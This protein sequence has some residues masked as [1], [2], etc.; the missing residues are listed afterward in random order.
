LSLAEISEDYT[1]MSLDSK[2]TLAYK[3]QEQAPAHSLYDLAYPSFIRKDGFKT[4]LS[5]SDYVDVL[6]SIL[7]AG[8][9]V[10]LNF[11]RV[12][13]R[14]GALAALYART[15]GG[16]A[17]QHDAATQNNGREVWTPRSRAGR[18]DDGKENRRPVGGDDRPRTEEEEEEGMSEKQ[19]RER[20]DEKERD[21]RKRNF[22]LAWDALEPNE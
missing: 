4:D 21:W 14:K 17:G 6:S 3:M 7:E 20:R 2:Q 16:M 18:E 19:K 9:G 11:E 13:N 5:A 10:R 1:N 8:T 12:R 22:W 15:R